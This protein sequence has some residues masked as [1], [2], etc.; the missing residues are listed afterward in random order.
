MLI[1]GSVNKSKT[2][3][4]VGSHRISQNDIKAKFLQI[5]NNSV[6]NS[7]FDIKTLPIEVIKSLSKEVYLER[8]LLKS[9]KKLEFIKTQ[10]LKIRS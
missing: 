2:I 1:N 10:M 4:K 3:S 9:A 5:F 8:E 6:D 7:N